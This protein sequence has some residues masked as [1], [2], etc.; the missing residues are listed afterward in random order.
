MEKVAKA[1]HER[2]KQNWTSSVLWYKTIDQIITN[3]CPTAF[4]LRS[5]KKGLQT[6]YEPVKQ[7]NCIA[8]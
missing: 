3:K 1:K 2:W 6:S 7:H 4:Q 5:Q 8:C